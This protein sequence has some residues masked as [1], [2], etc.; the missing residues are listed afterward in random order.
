MKQA[1][2]IAVLLLA[3]ALFAQ[4]PPAKE[5]LIPRTTLAPAVLASL[6]SHPALAYARYGERELQ[7][8]LHRPATHGSPLAAKIGRAHV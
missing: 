6:E 7:L 8:D 5:S 2:T 4:K 1:A 3:P